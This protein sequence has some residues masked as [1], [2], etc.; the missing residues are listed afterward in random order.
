MKLPKNTTDRVLLAALECGIKH[1]ST[2]AARS[3]I[4]KR[5][6]LLWWA[7]QRKLRARLACARTLTAEDDPAHVLRLISLQIIGIESFENDSLESLAQLYEEQVRPRLK[8]VKRAFWTVKALGVIALAA[9]AMGL[10]T[11]THRPFDPHQIPE[12]AQLE[13]ALSNWATASG[14]PNAATIEQQF[15]TADAQKRLGPDLCR[16][17]LLMLETGRAASQA[18]PD[19][20][21]DRALEFTKSQVLL[22]QTLVQRKLPVFVDGTLL[23]KANGLSPLLMTYYVEQR[24]SWQYGAQKLEAVSAWRMDPIRVRLPALGYVREGN[25]TAIIS[26]DLIEAVLVLYLLPSLEPNEP[27]FV[28]DEKTRFASDPYILGIEARLGNVLRQHFGAQKPDANT[29]RLGQLLAA[30]RNL[31]AKWRRAIT[32]FPI[33][34]PERVLP[35]RNLGEQL[36]PLISRGDA[37]DWDRINS[38]LARGDMINA[39]EQQ[40][41]DW[42]NA[43]KRHELQHLVDHSEKLLGIP[44]A[45][46][47]RL[48]VDPSIEPEPYSLFGAA[49]AELSA[50][51][52]EV[53][54]GPYPRLSLVQLT[55]AVFDRELANTPHHFAAETLFDGLMKSLGLTQD[56]PTYEEA[57][58]RVTETDP[59]L[60]RAKSRE[61]YEEWF[62]RALANVSRVATLEQPHW[63]H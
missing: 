48:R 5:D 54:D 63:R 46:A 57:V 45:L 28:F 52:A 15:R 38:E 33:H 32:G 22:N 42:A 62:G 47:R 17:V 18:K 30:R 55:A 7:A 25:P 31:I 51:L 24:E 21:K 8:P 40:R 19:E 27:A 23:P 10:Y 20:L 35:E 9:A 50:Y 43:V 44:V 37:A 2:N 6:P 1:S 39:F 41:R 59:Q 34:P 12:A 56:H 16:A 60:L 14:T 13:Q 26:Y 29:Q 61:L 53:G 4:S 36:E 3:A 49:R 58:V 11:A